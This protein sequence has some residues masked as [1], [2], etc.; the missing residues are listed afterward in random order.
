MEFDAIGLAVVVVIFGVAG[1]VKG[2]IG[3][4]VPTIAMGLLGALIAP[5][6]AAA[7]L[8]LPTVLT[9]VWQIW[10]G[11]AL[12]AML[13]RLWPMMAAIVF[14]TVAAAG[15]ITGANPRTTMALL[16][17]V[18]VAYAVLGLSG[19]RFRVPRRAER[20]A[21][22]AAGL[23]TGVINGATAIFAIPAV[24]YLQ[25]VDLDK[26][27]LV[28]AIGLSAL[29]SVLALAL[30]LGLNQGFDETVAVPTGLALVAALAG[31]AVGQAVRAKLSVAA[32]QRW[33]FIGQL[34]LGAMMIV[35]AVQ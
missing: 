22:P 21:G 18:L 19:Q 4:G 11:P 27:E 10:R 13:R 20:L 9:N 15:I 32:F 24:P 5:D 30:G 28:Q 26:D 23:T 16:G 29:V 35:R 2:V 1:I 6:Q 17:A 7:I 25:S 3:F 31:M 14:G 12:V 8:V 33:V 34:A